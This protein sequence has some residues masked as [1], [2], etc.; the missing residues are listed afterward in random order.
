M[1]IPQTNPCQP[2][3]CGPNSQ[4]Q[5]VGDSPSCSCLS[6][7]IGSPPNCRPECS[8][9]DEC[10]NNLAC[11]NKKCKDPCINSC[12]INAECR[13]SMHVPYCTCITDFTGDPFSSCIIL[14]DRKFQNIVSFFDVKK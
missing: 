14:K 8:N 12:G 2:S 9:N 1:Q 4:C 13:V 7:Y 11:L 5:V 3:P 10:F 6:E